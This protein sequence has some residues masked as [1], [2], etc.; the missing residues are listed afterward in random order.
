MVLLAE[1]LIWVTLITIIALNIVATILLMQKALV[2]DSGWYW[3]AA[4]VFGLFA[5]LA[6]LYTCYIHKRIK[7]AAAHLKVAGHAIF[8][9][10]MTIIVAIV[11][12]G[13]HIS[14]TMVWVISS[15]GVVFHYGFLQLDDLLC[16]KERCDLDYEPAAI[17]AVLCLMLLTYFWITFVLRNVIGVTTAGTI[18][19][20]KSAI[21]APCITIGSWVRAMTL[22][23]GSICLGSLIVAI[24]ETFVW[25]LHILTWLAGRSGNCCFVCLFSWLSRLVSSIER[26]IECFNRFAFSYVGCYNYSFVRA[27]RHV[28]K[29]FEAKGWS[30]IVND[31][32]IGNLCW[33]SNIVTG[34]L[35]AYVS[36]QLVH[37][38]DSEEHL[39]MFL[40]PQVVSAFFCFVAGYGIN[41]LVMSVITSAVTTIFVLWAEDPTGWHL[42]RPQQYETL[43][44][45]WHEIYPNEFRTGS[46]VTYCRYH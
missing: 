16:T 7:F 11:M 8:R 45:T 10:P 26:W 1:V 38:T 27:S 9:L 3:L 43:Y 14:W 32:L 37:A 30:A 28:F 25:L 46:E 44:K 40:H 34:V 21:N 36:V 17:I 5:L 22:N 6:M 41:T 23:L 12:V 39:A 29:L 31:H 20:W 24:L 15:L 35:T 18:A 4:M 2:S 33:L 13:V 42:T 19:A